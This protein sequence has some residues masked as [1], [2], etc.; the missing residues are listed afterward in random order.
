LHDYFLF[1]RAL[2]SLAIIFSMELPSYHESMQLRNRGLTGEHFGY[3]D[4]IFEHI[5]AV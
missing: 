2:T 4:P 3:D 1:R 5:H